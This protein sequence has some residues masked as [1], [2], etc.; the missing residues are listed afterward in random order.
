M[1]SAFFKHTPVL[2]GHKLLVLDGCE[3]LYQRDCHQAFIDWLSRLLT[4]NPELQ[5]LITARTH[6]QVS[7]D[8]SRD[9]LLGNLE[10]HTVEVRELSEADAVQML[11]W[12]CR[13]R[14]QLRA[15]AEAHGERIASFCGKLPFAID[16]FAQWAASQPSLRGAAA[17][18]LAEAEAAAAA[19]AA[20][21]PAAALDLALSALPGELPAALRRLLEAPRGPFGAALAAELWGVGRAEAEAR[22]AALRERRLLELA[23]SGPMAARLALP[24]G[25]EAPA[26]GPPC[27]R[28]HPL[29]QGHLRAGAGGGAAAAAGAEG[30]RSAGP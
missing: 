2:P 20:P 21:A 27:Y 1:G 28:L 19:A 18:L 3:E 10:D 16:L 29:L 4:E 25:A 17:A 26:P 7:T 12:I 8:H 22:L 24:P 30:G 6:L 9:P 14:P 23:D 15:L 13:A 5:L 11:R